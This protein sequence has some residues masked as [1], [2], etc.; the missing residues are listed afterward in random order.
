MNDKK[1]KNYE[2]LRKNFAIIF[3]TLKDILLVSNEPSIK[4][5]FLDRFLIVFFK[6][7]EHYIINYK[8]SLFN[9]N[10]LLY[11]LKINNNIDYEMLEIL[12]EN[13]INYSTFISLKRIE[14]LLKIKEY[15]YN[16]LDYLLPNF[17]FYFSY[18]ISGIYKLD[19]EH[20]NFNLNELQKLVKDFYIQAI[21]KNKKKE[22]AFY[23]SLIGASK[24]NFEIFIKNS[25]ILLN[26]KYVFSLSQINLLS[27][28]MFFVL[29]KIMTKFLNYDPILILDEPFVYLDKNNVKKILT[30]LK[31]NTQT[32]F[33][34]NNID[35]LH[36][37][38]DSFNNTNV[39]KLKSEPE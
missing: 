31:E 21:E 15:I 12:N 1:I 3:L 23:K 4:R 7:Y 5:D 6:D 25:D 28:A 35:L 19:L 36:F 30:V 39:I 18:Y 32:I 14:I 9:K 38:F 27:L 24:D 10:K 2:E 34:T 13:I 22:L 26:I 33:T 8:K 17:K 20:I 37:I 16:Y 11:N 29:K